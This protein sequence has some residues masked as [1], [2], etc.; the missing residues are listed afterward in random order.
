M[1]NIDKISQIIN[2]NYNKIYLERIWVN[3]N[4]TEIDNRIGVSTTDDI[5]HT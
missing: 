5:I 2:K 3:T 1:H 4:G